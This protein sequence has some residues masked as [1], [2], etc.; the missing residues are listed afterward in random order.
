MLSPKGSK[1]NIYGVHTELR[2]PFTQHCPEHSADLSWGWRA[3]SLHRPKWL[4]LWETHHAS[5]PFQTPSEYPGLPHKLKAS[6]CKP[7]RRSTSPAKKSP[8]TKAAKKREVT[9]CT[10][11]KLN[12]P[13]E[14][15]LTMALQIGRLTGPRQRQ[16]H[17][18]VQG[19]GCG[20]WAALCLWKMARGANLITQ[21]RRL[22]FC[23]G[24][25]IFIN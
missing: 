5:V 3:T 7:N 14:L 23:L 25:L 2:P 24:P 1:E 16:A 21:G 20:W 22:G 17:T 12:Q 9:S 13:S 4:Q 6:I 18:T 8:S 10:G 15:S 11:E 19:Q